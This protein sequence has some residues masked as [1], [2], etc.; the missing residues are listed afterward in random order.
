MR[1]W[2]WR[3]MYPFAGLASGL[4]L[5]SCKWKNAGYFAWTERRGGFYEYRWFGEVP[6]RI[7][8]SVSLGGIPYRVTVAEGLVSF[9]NNSGV[10]STRIEFRRD[11][12]DQYAFLW[13]STVSGEFAVCHFERAYDW[14]KAVYG[15]SHVIK[16]PPEGQMDRIPL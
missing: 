14:V 15:G 1:R 3:L 6:E 4:G 7:P 9:R 2:F 5:I 12:H 16:K 10:S 13:Y 8:D 11:P